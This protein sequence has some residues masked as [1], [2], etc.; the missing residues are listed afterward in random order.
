M[1]EAGI[2]DALV[3]SELLAID[4]IE[5]ATS[6]EQNAA[7]EALA[8]I[9]RSIKG[10]DPASLRRIA[11]RMSRRGFELDTIRAALRQCG[12]DES[13]LDDDFDQESNP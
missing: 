2:T 9:R 5:P 6:P 13:M 12:L 4:S 7:Q 11:A 3:S 1:S 8:R 10:T